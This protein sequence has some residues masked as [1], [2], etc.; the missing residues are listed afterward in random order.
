MTQPFSENEPYLETDLPVDIPEAPYRT[1]S[2]LSLGF[3]LKW[4]TVFFLFIVS[5]IL[6]LIISRSTTQ[7]P[8]IRIL[9][10]YHPNESTRIFD[11]SGNLVANIHGDEDRV[12]VPLKDISPNIQ[13]AIMAI[14]DNR[15]YEHNGIDPRGSVRAFVA[16]MNADEHVQGGSTLTQQLVKNLFLT[17]EKSYARKIAEAVLAMRVEKHYSKDQ[18]LEMYLNQVYF[19]NLSY[20]IEKAARRYFKVSAKQLSVAQ[21][22]LLAGL[23]KAPEGLSPYSYPEAARKRQLEVLDKM[24]EYGYITQKQHDE[25]VNEKIVLNSRE[26][27]PSK[28]PYFM[29]YVIQELEKRYG[30]DV[31]RRGGLRVYTTLDEKAQDIADKVMFD[32]VTK[33]PAG[34]GIKQ[35]AFVSLDV[36]TGNILAMVGGI[37]FEK[38]QFNAATQARRAV[39]STFKPFVYLTAFRLGKITANTPIS[40]HPVSYGGWSPHNWDGKYLGPMT[41]RKALTLSRNTTT[42]QVGMKVGIP[43]ITKTCQAAGIVSPIDQNSSSFLGSSGVSLLELVTAYSTFAR[44]GVYL[45]PTAIKRVEDSRG[46]E[47]KID[48]PTPKRVFDQDDVAAL[49]DI[50]IDVVEKGTGK[51]AILD[52]RVV[53]GKT[54]TTDQMRDIWFMGFTPDMVAGLWM[55]DPKNTPMHGVYGADAAKAWHAYAVEY[56][57]SHAIPPQ[58]FFIASNEYAAK[59]GLIHLVDPKGLA[60]AKQKL[61]IQKLANEDNSEQIGQ[62]KSA[63]TSSA[64]KPKPTSANKKKD[65]NNVSEPKPDNSTD[66]DD[67]DTTQT[68]NQNKKSFS[69]PALRET[70]NEKQQKFNNWEKTLDNLKQNLNN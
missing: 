37:D 36:Q 17:P 6:G 47:V 42:V 40:D 44:G 60:E 25:A 46:R 9:E 45:Q 27:K 43:E 48:S 31:V 12:V 20:G 28:Y 65:P 7:L 8:D 2:G 5:V 64:T 70:P 58:Q 49:I 13:R 1:K 18:I 30:E 66:S 68:V 29:A 34:S 57:Q 14:E 53:A 32:A 24:V 4:G 41:I 50:L 16:D 23:L 35:G 3:F 10:D 38:N 51:N 54:G 69:T 21:A 39:G 55:G 67:S 11:R 33:A 19:G 52:D 15:F 56:Y 26:A 61:G 22:A 63:P 59:M 62:K